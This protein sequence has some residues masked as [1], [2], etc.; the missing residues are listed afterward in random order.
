MDSLEITPEEIAYVAGR[1][2]NY[3]K[4]ERGDL[5][6]LIHILGKSG[7]FEH[8]ELIEKFIYESKDPF[9]VGI[10]FN[11]VL[12]YFDFILDYGN[13]IK[14]F[15]KGVDWDTDDDI[16]ISALSTAGRYLTGI[17]DVEM[18]RCLIKTLEDVTEEEW[19]RES[20]FE[21][22]ATFVRWMPQGFTGATQQDYE[23][24]Y[25]QANLELARMEGDNHE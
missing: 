14:V 3:Q 1:I 6:T 21:G 19:I 16:R 15:M 17:D 22:L 20:A 4:E 11:A 9:I 5:Y 8:R 18:L 25:Q 10:A 12:N 13:E 23:D 7:A 2:K 24:V